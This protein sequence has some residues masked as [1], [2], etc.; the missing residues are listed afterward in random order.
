MSSSSRARKRTQEEF[1]HTFNDLYDARK[2]IVVSSDAAPKEIPDLEERLRSRFEWVSSRHPAP[3]LRTRV[4]ILKKKAEIE[5]VSCPT[6]SPSD[7][8][9]HQGK[10]SRDR[11][12]PHADD[13]LL[14]LSGAR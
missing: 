4:A 11:G 7:R 5:R 3:G 12:I 14:L 2:Q 1:F 10:Y 8:Q 13:R 6:T 9:P